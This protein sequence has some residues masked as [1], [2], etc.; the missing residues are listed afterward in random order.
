MRAI[1]LAA[2][3]GR[4][5]DGRHPP[6]PLL[7][8]GGK[9]LLE[10]HIEVLRSRGVD[11]LVLIVGHRETE[12]RGEVAR[13]GAEDFVHLQRNPDYARG[14]ILSLWCARA[15]LSSA[16]G[17]LVMDADVLYHPGLMDRLLGSPHTDCLLL[18]RNFEPG[19]EPVKVGV[20][21][22]QVVEFGKLINGAELDLLGEWPGFVK[23]SAPACRALV[24]IM[25]E[26][27]EAGRIDAPME[28]AL[29][30]LILRHPGILQW[31]DITGL[32][33]IEIDFARDL[34]RAREEVL[35]RI[36][37]VGQPLA[38]ESV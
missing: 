19:D 27:I 6:K 20:S 22:G 9:S 14:S 34:E 12:L 30:N 33:W 2:G 24:R 29:R 10:R 28:D 11:H 7:S 18:D 23:L 17:V 13:L 16:T 35:P 21:N 32:P 5:L 37:P 15:T 4:R 3:I 1:M 31:E 36:E 25:H 8:V 26:L 38:L